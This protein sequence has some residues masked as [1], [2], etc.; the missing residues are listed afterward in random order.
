[1]NQLR[2]PCDTT[3][4]LKYPVCKS[5]ETI[6]CH[7]LYEYVTTHRN[8]VNLIEKDYWWSVNIVPYFHSVLRIKPEGKNGWNYHASSI[9]V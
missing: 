7:L 8:Y 1:M 2:V 9:S 5:K 6:K 3:K 4:C